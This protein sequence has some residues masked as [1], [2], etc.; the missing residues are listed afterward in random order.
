MPPGFP[1][2]TVGDAQTWLGRSHS[3]TPLAVRDG[4]ELTVSPPWDA[5]VPQG[6]VLYYVAGERIDAAR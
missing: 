2:R 6:S 4:G 3:A 1:H 5:P